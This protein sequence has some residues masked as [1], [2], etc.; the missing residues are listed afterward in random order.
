MLS[1]RTLTCALVAA[2]LAFSA[3]AFASKGVVDL[4]DDTYN[5][6]VRPVPKA[7]WLRMDHEDHAH[8]RAPRRPS[9][10]GVY[11]RRIRIGSREPVTVY[12]THWRSP[13]KKRICSISGTGPR[14][15]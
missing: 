2:L 12:T 10:G 11:P 15:C 13:S 4:T 8:T 7:P 1:A 3:P 5:S 9:G 14:I 6:A